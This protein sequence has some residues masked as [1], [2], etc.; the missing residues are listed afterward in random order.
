MKKEESIE[1]RQN[2]LAECCKLVNVAF[3]QENMNRFHIIGHSNWKNVNVKFSEIPEILL[4]GFI[5][6]EVAV[7]WPARID[8][9]E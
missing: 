1:D 3:N 4:E 8:L 2:T 9:L 7:L 6:K 5:W